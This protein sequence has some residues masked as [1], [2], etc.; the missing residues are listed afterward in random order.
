MIFAIPKEDISK[1]RSMKIIHCADIHL[2]SQMTANLDKVKAKER[3]HEIL[4]TFLRMV[5][6]AEN[7]NIDAVIIAGDLFDTKSFSA[8][9]RNSVVDAI[10]SHQ[11]IA[12]YYLKGNHG[13][14]DH[15]IDAIKEIPDNLHLFEESWKKYNLFEKEGKRITLSGIELSNDNIS[16]V[17]SSLL[18]DPR[19]FN[20]VTMHGQI[21]TYQVK[22]SPDNIS[23]SDLR[24]KNIDYLALGHIHE[25]QEGSLPPR[26]KYCYCGCLEGRGFDEC[27]K[28]GFVV[29]DID[30]GDFTY[31]TEFIDFA[32]RHLYEIPV[33][34]S[35]C[36]TNA[37]IRGKIDAAIG[38]QKSE[39]KD[40]LKIVL[41]GDIEVDCE[42]NTEYLA[43]ILLERFYFAKVKDKTKIAVDYN[44]YEL[45]ASLKGEFVRIVKG[46]E[47]LTEEEKAEIIRCG[48]QALNG[49]D[50][51]L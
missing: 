29:L 36:K 28:H 33:D 37:D 3:K 22:T 2:D 24:N 7:N 43:K 23:L 44:D 17:Y 46:D 12:F 16:T 20:I 5:D 49:E 15:F 19:D 1:E 45:D 11:D 8:G 47:S 10:V 27:G 13:G 34:I 38:L 9:T 51:E 30:E 48:F 31:N 4:D 42:K 39:T 40:L 26:G 41:T 50:I 18:L 6:Y 21:S 32:K 25:Y 14:G 35:D